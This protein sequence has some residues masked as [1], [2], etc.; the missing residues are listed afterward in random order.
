MEGV[1]VVPVRIEQNALQTEGKRGKKEWDERD[2]AF[3]AEQVFICQKDGGKHHRQFLR[4]VCQPECREA[5]DPPAIREQKDAGEAKGGA[6][7]IEDVHRL[8]VS[9][10]GRCAECENGGSAQSLPDPDTQFAE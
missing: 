3:S 2:K 5:E 6:E 1:L 9:I 4:L 7:Q 10:E 8:P